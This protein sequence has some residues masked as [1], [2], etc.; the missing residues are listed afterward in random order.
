MLDISFRCKSVASTDYFSGNRTMV[1]CGS[2]CTLVGGGKRGVGGVGRIRF[3]RL[4][5]GRGSPLGASSGEF[6]RSSE[7]GVVSRGKGCKLRSGKA[8]VTRPRFSSFSARCG[9]NVLITMSGNGCKILGI[10]RKRVDVAASVRKGDSGRLRISEGNRL[11]PIAISCA[12][13]SCVRG[14]GIL[15]S[16]NSNACHSF[17]SRK[18]NGKL[19]RSLSVAPIVRG[20]DRSYEVGI[21][22]RRSKV[23]LTNVRG[24]FTIDC[25]VGLHI[26]S[27]NPSAVQT[28]R[29]CATAFDS[30][31]FGSS[32]GRIAIA[33]A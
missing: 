32:G 16:L 17:A 11:A 6:S 7:C 4:C 15:I 13:P 27:P 14:P 25:P 12:V 30:A 3:G 22:V 28:G 5:R 23:L 31:V 19:G 29:G 20:G 2:S 8:V 10:S 9:S 21:T 18:A 24:A 1:T 26:S 33:T